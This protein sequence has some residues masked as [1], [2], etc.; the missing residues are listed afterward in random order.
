MINFGP[1]PD[2]GRV[3]FETRAAPHNTALENIRLS[4]G[5]PNYPAI[6]AYLDVRRNE[7]W[8]E[9]KPYFM[10][11]QHRKCGFC[12]VK[13]TESTGDVEHYRPK[14]A[15]WRL[16]FRG[17]ELDDLVNVRGRTYNETYDSGYWWLAYSWDNYLVACPRCNQTWKSA[18]F[19]IAERRRREPHRGDENAETPL[20]LSPFGDQNPS[21][22]LVFGPFGTIEA[23]NESRIGQK[24]IETCGLDRE[25]LRS[26][27]EEKAQ[28][29]Y[30]LVQRLSEADSSE[31]TREILD[32]IRELGRVEYAHA[33]MV[34]AIF[35]QETGIDWSQLG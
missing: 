16:R 14:K 4:D 18:L 32:D 21:A 34:R 11:A 23:Y 5:S 10:R 6:N 13:I 24:T 9:A 7:I 33:G 17:R 19:P 25:S 20:L 26:S 15:M 29:I 28:R 3:A 27:R 22:H 8:G 1:R 12:E 35:E 30:R 2:D 31:E